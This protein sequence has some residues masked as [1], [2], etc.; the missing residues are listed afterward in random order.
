M[1]LLHLQETLRTALAMGVD[2]AVHVVADADL[3][4]L[5][6]A[7]ILKAMVDR[8]NPHIVMLGKQAIDDDCNQ[9]V[10]PEVHTDVLILQKLYRRGMSL[11][12]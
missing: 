10:C 12:E 11:Q 7:Q 3:Q 1:R 9:T 6:I 8:N 5:Y 4:P 2:K